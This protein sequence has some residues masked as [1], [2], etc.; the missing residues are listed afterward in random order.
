MNPKRLLLR[1]YGE[2]RDG[3]W[4]LIN[5]EFSLAAQAA[6]FDE[7]KASLDVQ[8]REY[9]KDALGGQDRAH[10]DYLLARRAPIKYWLKYWVALLRARTLGAENGHS[11]SF[12]ET[13]P[14]APA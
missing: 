14:L 12:R 1:M 4:T 2:Q 7:A 3:Q 11:Q 8:I 5:L 9:V 6:S 10:A 13:V